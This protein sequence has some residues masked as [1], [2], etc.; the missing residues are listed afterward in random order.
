V[1]ESS[2]AASP[3]TGSSSSLLHDMAGI[4]ARRNHHIDAAAVKV[5]MMRQ[6]MTIDDLKAAV[7]TQVSRL[8]LPQSRQMQRRIEYLIDKEYMKR[9][10]DDE[11]ILEYVA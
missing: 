9:S 4:E 1:G 2:A 5:L 10:D 11:N 7:V 8:F 3:P 6:K